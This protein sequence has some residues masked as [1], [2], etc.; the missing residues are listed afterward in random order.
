MNTVLEFFF[1]S[2]Y[3][4]IFLKFDSVTS[5]NPNAVNLLRSNNQCSTIATTTTTTSSFTIG[6]GPNN[7]PNELT[8]LSPALP[9]STDSINVSA[10]A[11]STGPI[12]PVLIGPNQTRIIR[13]TMS[14]PQKFSGGSLAVGQVQQPRSGQSFGTRVHP[15][16]IN[17]T[18]GVP[19]K[20]DE[21]ELLI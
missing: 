6:I 5:L 13:P 10:G 20:G 15:V 21:F 1:Q 16:P 2:K 3:L 11:L 9:Q 18:V 12:K 14:T 19:N 7:T 4:A 17:V 8:V